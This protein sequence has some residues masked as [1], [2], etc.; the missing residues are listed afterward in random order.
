MATFANQTSNIS[1]LKSKFHYLLQTKS[2]SDDDT[3]T[4]R[5]ANAQRFISTQTARIHRV[6]KELLLATQDILPSSNES[7]TITELAE[8]CRL[9]QTAS[10][11]KLEL[12]KRRLQEAGYTVYSPVRSSAEKPEPRRYTRH[13]TD[14]TAAAS[15]SSLLR[16]TTGRSPTPS[17]ANVT[18]DI[19]ASTS[20]SILPWMLT[21]TIGGPLESV[22]EGDA[23]TDGATTPGSI[24]QSPSP[25]LWNSSAK[26]IQGSSR[27]P[28]SFASP[29]RNKITNIHTNSISPSMPR[30]S[31]S[32]STADF[33]RRQQEQQQ[34]QQQQDCND[35]ASN[36]LREEIQ[37]HRTPEKSKS[38][39]SSF[40]QRT[41]RT[42]T[43]KA[44]HDGQ[45]NQQQNRPWNT[46]FREED[47]MITLDTQSTFTKPASPIRHATTSTETKESPSQREDR[48]SFFARMEGMLNRVEESIMEN[49]SPPRRY[50]GD[51]PSRPSDEIQ[52]SLSMMPRSEAPKQQYSHYQR[53]AHR[54]LYQEESYSN[55]SVNCNS[56]DDNEDGCDD[57]DDE[58]DSSTNMAPTLIAEKNQSFRHVASKSIGWSTDEK[59]SKRPHPL[60]TPQQQQ[61]VQI[62]RPT[63]I[64]VDRAISSPAHTNITM[65]ATMMN[66]TF[67]SF[68]GMDETQLREKMAPTQEHPNYRFNDDDTT[69][70]LST[71][72]PVLDRYRLDPDDENSIG[73]KVV[74]N[75]R[76][77][78]QK[79]LVQTSGQKQGSHP[80]MTSSSRPKTPKE[81]ATLPIFSASDF[82]SPQQTPTAVTARPLQQRTPGSISTQNKKVYRKTPFPKRKATHEQESN[83]STF[84]ENEHPNTS[85]GSSVAASPGVFQKSLAPIESISITVP[86]LRPRSLD[87][88]R[89]E[90]NFSIAKG[91]YVS[92]DPL[93]ISN[94]HR[95]KNSTMQRIDQEE[96]ATIDQIDKTI[97]RIDQ[98]LA[99]GGNTVEM[100]DLSSGRVDP[101]G[102]SF[103][104]QVKSMTQ[105]NT[106]ARPSLKS[107]NLKKITVEEF[108]QAPRIVRTQ[109]SVEEANHALDLLQEFCNHG[110][111]E[112]NP[113]LQFS[114]ERGH[115]MLSSLTGSKHRSKSILISLCHW[116]RLSMRRDT[117]RGTMVF[118]VNSA[119]KDRAF[120]C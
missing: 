18:H 97:E 61:Q 20:A 98:E 119:A 120:L 92:F 110:P 46:E 9:T 85:T 23:E 8:L 56:L 52:A 77:S 113:S 49:P 112:E 10:R 40:V 11:Q 96:N 64:L 101:V 26:K 63:H 108:E 31:L 87:S 100:V 42:Q 83:S 19:D 109:V 37:P 14:S 53:A 79:P 118:V 91:P 84:N 116:Q 67:A 38:S 65:D 82:L 114:E 69:D 48:S 17:S 86:P 29:I 93:Q 43:P 44:R 75:E 30:L 106:A 95:S 51:E 13:V 88:R 90:E 33:L 47:D 99:I 60:N 35:K 7:K 105:T 55:G 94:K 58:D 54:S 34:Q 104:S 36:P 76:G 57:E 71:V 24:L 89:L 21:S 15:T 72:T 68:L 32:A 1:A 25:M 62:Q 50:R 28:L 12:L 74:P 16:N 103:L 27:M 2:E 81:T 102:K 59:D 45:Q 6:E 107:S 80:F 4:A 115:E 73:V 70:N 41:Q 22:L 39:V 117:V 111:M 5:E 3:D 78:H 66:D